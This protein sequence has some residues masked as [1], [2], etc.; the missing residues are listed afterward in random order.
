MSTS[1]QSG[2]TSG[3][4]SPNVTDPPITES[5]ARQVLIACRHTCCLCYSHLVVIHHIRYLVH[6]GGSS[7]DNLVPLCPNCHTKVH[8][9]QAA[10]G[11]PGVTAR[12]YS[13]A[14]LR[15]LRDAWYEQ[16]SKA[17][18]LL[19]SDVFRRGDWHYYV[20]KARI[21]V[22]WSEQPRPEPD[23]TW[24]EEPQNIG[25]AQLRREY[26]DKLEQIIDAYGFVDLGIILREPVAI[27]GQ[28]RGLNV[29]YSGR[30][31]GDVGLRGDYFNDDGPLKETLVTLESAV[32]VP[33]GEG[34]VSVKMDLDPVYITTTTT[35]AQLRETP[36]LHVVGRVLDV[37]GSPRSRIIKVSPLHIKPGNGE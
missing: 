33:A 15:D 2:T 7:F 27:D 11:K 4:G 6:G 24:S 13:E 18:T 21:D 25:D 17:R 34:E 37:T 5:I 32:A 28:L 16:C 35:F 12:A 22:L 30:F 31:A 26:A 14:E 8:T 9:S 19:H 1:K 29:A 23:P 10:R 36:Y 3:H 20:N